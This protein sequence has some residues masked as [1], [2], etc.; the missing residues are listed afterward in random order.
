MTSFSLS[1]Q[2]RLR[3]RGSA[4]DQALGWAMIF[5]Y[6]QI[7]GNTLEGYCPEDDF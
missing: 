3:L 6:F 2:R 7:I 1:S 4:A 5:R